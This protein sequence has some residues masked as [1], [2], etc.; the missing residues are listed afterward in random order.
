VA[1]IHGTGAGN[2]TLRTGAILSVVLAAGL[3]G[4][5]KPSGGKSIERTPGATSQPHVS[6]GELVAVREDWPSG[7]P[8][9]RA[10]M[11]RKPDGTLVEHGTYARWYD[12]GQK[13]Y[14]ATY[15]HGKL[16]G[17]ESAWHRNGQ[18]YSEQWY[19]AGLRHGQ[20]RTWDDQ[21]RLRSEEHYADDRPTGVW[22][23][24]DEQGRLR[25]E[26][27]AGDAPTPEGDRVIR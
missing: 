23:V 11:L 8:F 14:E 10:T 26:R 1:A 22:R 3:G 9:V 24:W 7:Q 18:Q 19:H 13:E 12:S 21:G 27:K 6:D 16:E 25:H 4:C 15:D 20:R 2:M 5:V 17:L